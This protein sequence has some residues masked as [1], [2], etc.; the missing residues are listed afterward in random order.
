[1][2]VKLIPVK[3]YGREEYKPANEL[4]KKIAKWLNKKNLSDEDKLFIQELGLEPVVLEY[5]EPTSS[6]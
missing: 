6:C 4:G 2:K 3:N 5:G 1:M